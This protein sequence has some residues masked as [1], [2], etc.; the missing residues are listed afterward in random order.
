ME[1]EEIYVFKSYYAFYE[2][3]EDAIYLLPQ[4]SVADSDTML[5]VLLHEI[6]HSLVS[7]WED[8]DDNILVEGL[9]DSIAYETATKAGYEATPKYQEAILCI[10]ML[11]DIYGEEEVVKAICEDKIVELIDNSTEPGMAEKLNLALNICHVGPTADDVLNA[12]NVELEILAHAAKDQ[13][14]DI[15]KWFDA[16][17]AIYEAN[18]I[19]LKIEYFKRI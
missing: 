7:N 2:N 6:S 17:A 1:Y 18:G 14:V 3:T 4:F 8:Q 15:D 16:L 10:R 19:K 5:Y 9:V 13:G 11:M 12:T